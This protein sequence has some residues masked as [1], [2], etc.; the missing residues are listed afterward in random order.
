MLPRREQCRVVQGAAE[1][2]GQ[3][4]LRYDACVSA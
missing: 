4:L 1:W 2:A 3:G